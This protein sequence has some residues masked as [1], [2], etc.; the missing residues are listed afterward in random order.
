M[1][2]LDELMDRDPLE[3]SSQDID[4]IIS[5]QRKHRANV[6]GGKKAKKDDGPGVTLDLK[7]LGLVP[8]TPTVRLDN[9]SI[10]RRV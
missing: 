10:K 2:D 1:S 7:A 8:Q 6:A 4:Q 9:G 5:Y 3:L